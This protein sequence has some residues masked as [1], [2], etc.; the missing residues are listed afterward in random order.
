VE[1]LFDVQV[2]PGIVSPYVSGPAAEKDTGQPLW[3]VPLRIIRE[4]VDWFVAG[5]C[6]T[7]R[8]DAGATRVVSLRGH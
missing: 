6:R 3:A 5:L 2:L 8:Q 4:R 1:E 7:C